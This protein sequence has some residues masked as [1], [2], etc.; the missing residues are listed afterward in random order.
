MSQTKR[1]HYVPESYLKQFAFPR[2]FGKDNENDL[3]VW[4]QRIDVHLF[5]PKPIEV[6]KGLCTEEYFYTI[7]TEHS[8]INAFWGDNF[9][10]DNPNVIEDF[11]FPYENNLPALFKILKHSNLFSNFSISKKD[12]E[13]LSYA[14]V[15]IKWRNPFIR[16]IYNLEDISSLIEETKEGLLNTIEKDKLLR[17]YDTFLLEKSKQMVSKFLQDLSNPT[18]LIKIL[19]SISSYI[20]GPINRIYNDLITRFVNCHW[21]IIQTDI[22]NQFITSDNPGIFLGGERVVHS[23]TTLKQ[24]ERLKFDRFFFPLSGL[25]GLLIHLSVPDRVSTLFEKKIDIIYSPQ[26]VLEYNAGHCLHVNKILIASNKQALKVAWKK[27]KD[28]WINK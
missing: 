19:H 27:G 17:Q 6:G 21:T 1:Q 14:I 10:K 16:K 3:S 28:S 18:E 23:F 15:D 8:F 7:N 2:K 13:T 12:M 4:T 24:I 20:D 5:S 11:G 26:S 22:N 9:N 25:H